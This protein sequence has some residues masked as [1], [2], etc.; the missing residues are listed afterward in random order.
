VTAD[1]GEVITVSLAS[2][3]RDAEHV[4]MA[5][6][7]GATRQAKVRLVVGELCSMSKLDE[8]IET[9]LAHLGH[10]LGLLPPLIEIQCRQR[11]LGGVN[12]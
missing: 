7:Y 1:A 3:E 10:T 11:L 9:H 8:L 2:I 6:R 5:L 4:Q 12:R